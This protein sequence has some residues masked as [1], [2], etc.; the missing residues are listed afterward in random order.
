MDVGAPDSQ[1]EEQIGATIMP[2]SPTT[3]A[4]QAAAEATPIATT[5]P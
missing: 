1:V 3:S 5:R 4:A 2:L